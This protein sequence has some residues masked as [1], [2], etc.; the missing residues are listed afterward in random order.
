MTRVTASVACI[1]AA[2]SF[3]APVQATPIVLHT[4]LSGLNENPPNA[5]PGTG[6]ATVTYDDTAH[7]L[8]VNITFSGL[9]GTT[10]TAHIHC[11]FAS[12]GNAGVATITPTFPGFP[13]GVT[14]GVYDMLFDLTMAGSFNAAFVTANGGSAASA[15]VALVS[16][17]LAGQAYVNIHTSTFG[18][19]EIRGFL[20]VPEPAA[21][22][23]LGIGLAGL[24]TARR[25]DS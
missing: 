14:S 24:L 5:S 9:T 4:T 1:I 12:P 13:Q 6:Y 17:L 20:A 21:L 7:T 15:E 19:G 11:C 16:G 18:G 8:G 22:A 23:L 25:R 2:L 3:V 10:T